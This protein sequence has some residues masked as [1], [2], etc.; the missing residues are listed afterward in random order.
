MSK[1]QLKHTIPMW[2]HTFSKDELSLSDC[3]ANEEILIPSLYSLFQNVAFMDVERLPSLTRENLEAKGLAWMIAEN[4]CRLLPHRVY[5]PAELISETWSPG[6]KGVYFIRNSACWREK[7]TW[8][9]LFA[10]ASAKWFL[11]N[12]KER[13]IVR[14]DEVIGMEELS[15][16]KHD[17]QEMQFPTKRLPSLLKEINQPASYDFFMERSVEYSYIDLN[18]HLNNTHYLAFALDC[19]ARYLKEQDLNPWN[20]KVRELH[21]N[22]SSEVF[23]WQ[24]LRIY[25]KEQAYQSSNDLEGNSILHNFRLGDKVRSFLLEGLNLDTNRS[26]FKQE[27]VVEEASA[28]NA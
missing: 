11:V 25:L 20:Y 14:P 1:P 3:D 26:A 23:A 16:T 15:L 12:K 9:G 10:L 21:T 17:W 22:Y 2:T 6:L 7:R 5:S 27:I 8:P 19:L 4:S 13:K 18:S 24:T 28:N